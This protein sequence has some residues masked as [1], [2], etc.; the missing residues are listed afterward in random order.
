M[1]DRAI[2]AGQWRSVTGIELSGRT[3]GL[4]GFGG[5]ARNLAQLAS[6]IGMRVLTW[7]RNNSSQRAS[8]SGGTAVDLDVLLSEADVVSVHLN[9]NDQTRRFVGVDMFNRMKAG[10]IFINT[11]RGGLVDEDALVASL[12]SGRLSGAGLD[13]FAQEPLPGDHPLLKFENVVLTPVSAW[14]TI[15]AADR[16]IG[17]SIDNVLRFLD[18]RP[19]N[20][21]NSDYATVA[22][23]AVKP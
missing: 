20:I 14:N 1:Q 6:A 9:L 12:N 21:C 4:I 2:R 16:M 5:I 18:D 13:V 22:N 3:L 19:Q 10:A 7:S 15:E 11:A 8:Q 23:H 17:T